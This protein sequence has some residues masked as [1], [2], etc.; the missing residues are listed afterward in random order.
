MAYSKEKWTNY[1]FRA[2]GINDVFA[3]NSKNWPSMSGGKYIISGRIGS[4]DVEY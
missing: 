3:F 4:P 2:E 1:K